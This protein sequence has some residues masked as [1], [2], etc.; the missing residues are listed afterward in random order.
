MVLNGLTNGF[1]HFTLSND[2]GG[3]GDLPLGRRGVARILSAPL[4]LPRELF[5][6]ERQEEYNILQLQRGNA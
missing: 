4:G 5:A 2:F 6:G 1:L 3:P